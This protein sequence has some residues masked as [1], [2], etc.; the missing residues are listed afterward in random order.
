MRIISRIAAQKNADPT[1]L[2]P[3]YEAI[4]P[5]ALK[6]LFAPQFDGTTRTNG[7]VVFAYSGY[8]ITVTSDGDIQTT[9]LENS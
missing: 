5:G 6:E 8:Q 4:D 9:P 1:S 2:E 3:L 7:R